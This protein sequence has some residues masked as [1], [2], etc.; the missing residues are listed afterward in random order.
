MDVFGMFLEWMI[1]WIWVNMLILSLN[2]MDLVKI[3]WFLTDQL[4]FG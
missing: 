3:G 2:A 1:K 4:A